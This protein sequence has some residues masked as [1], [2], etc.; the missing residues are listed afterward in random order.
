M[1]IVCQC[2]PVRDRA[3]IKAIQHGACTLVDVQATCGA[4]TQCGGCEPAIRA[5]IER[6]AQQI[7][8]PVLHETAGARA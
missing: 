6:Y 7:T 2:I 4:A 3:V 8:E 1:A 5:L